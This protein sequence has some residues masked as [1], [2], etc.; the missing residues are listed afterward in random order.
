MTNVLQLFWQPEQLTKPQKPAVLPLPNKSKKR[1]QETLIVADT[2]CKT[3]DY[4]CLKCG[5]QSQFGTT[6]SIQC[7]KCNYRVL[8]KIRSKKPI[9]YNAV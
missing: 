4:I 8:E 6:S 5:Q 1:K 7:P 3:V 2:N 9:A